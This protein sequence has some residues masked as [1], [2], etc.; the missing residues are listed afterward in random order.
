MMAGRGAS[1]GAVFHSGRDF[2]DMYFLLKAPAHPVH[3][4][5]ARLYLVQRSGAYIGNASLS[6]ESISLATQ[7]ARLVSAQSLDLQ[8]AST[9]G[10][11]DLQLSSDADARWINPGEVLAFHFHLDGAPSGDLRAYT[12]FELVVDPTRVNFIYLPLCIVSDPD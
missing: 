5:A 12:I 3:V 1:A 4:T 10:W 2:S 11:L 8:G 7:V 6:L 9:G